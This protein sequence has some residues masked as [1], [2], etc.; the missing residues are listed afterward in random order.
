MLLFPTVR[1]SAWA[2]GPVHLCP[3]KTHL[4]LKSIWSMVPELPHGPWGWVVTVRWRT[5]PRTED[6]FIP[7]DLSRNDLTECPR[8]LEN[9]KNM[10]VLNLGHNRWGSWQH[11]SP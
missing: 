9:A 8:E 10:L 6:A 4:G 3:L 7:Q 11:N 2:P 5:H 1:A